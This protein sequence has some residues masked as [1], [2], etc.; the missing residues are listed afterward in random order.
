MFK[1]SASNV[2]INFQQSP[3]CFFRCD[4]AYSVIFIFTIVRKW[5]SKIRIIYWNH[6]LYAS[7]KHARVFIFTPFLRLDIQRS[8]YVSPR[9][10]SF[11]FLLLSYRVNWHLCS[12]CVVCLISI[13]IFDPI[14]PFVLKFVLIPPLEC[15]W[16]RV[17]S[18]LA[19]E[20][21]LLS[22]LHSW[23][24]N[25]IPKLSLERIPTAYDWFQYWDNM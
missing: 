3:L 21:C 12:F 2:M 25:F 17:F 11:L 5:L 23:H 10:L 19:I 9:I 15:P 22:S 24:K 4:V 13:C 8:M 1:Y 20:Y 16:S 18:L 6:G 14:W 7:P